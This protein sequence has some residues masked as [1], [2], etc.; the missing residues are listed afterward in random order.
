MGE[1]VNAD[2][3]IVIRAHDYTTRWRLP[4]GMI[5]HEDDAECAAGCAASAEH[6]AANREQM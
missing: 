3:N 5:R 2:C 1:L 4:E 6:P